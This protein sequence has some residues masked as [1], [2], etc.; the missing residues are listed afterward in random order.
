MKTEIRGAW[1]KKKVAEM[2]GR[3]KGIHEELKYKAG[4]TKWLENSCP[5][6]SE[7]T[8]QRKGKSRHGRMTEVWKN[9][10]QV[11][12]KQKNQEV[13]SKGWLRTL[14]T[15]CKMQDEWLYI[16]KIKRQHKRNKQ[17]KETIY[18]SVAL[19]FLRWKIL[20]VRDLLRD[21]WS[22][23]ALLPRE[24]ESLASSSAPAMY[25]SL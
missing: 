12:S 18:A 20:R 9:E 10:K 8:M 1:K 7:K 6:G 4:E 19:D 24:R 16:S 5:G 2:I 21:F 3:M 22:P 25:F 14:Q 13:G 11:W 17:R 23:L 15:W